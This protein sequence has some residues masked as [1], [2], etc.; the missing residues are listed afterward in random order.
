MRGKY[1]SATG[2]RQSR[3]LHRCS[4]YDY[5]SWQDIHKCAVVALI[6]FN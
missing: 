1:V 6:S 4:V 2:E 5:Q 3:D